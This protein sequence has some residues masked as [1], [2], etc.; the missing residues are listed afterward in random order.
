[1]SYTLIKRRRIELTEFELT[2]Y[3]HAPALHECARTTWERSRNSCTSS[4]KGAFPCMTDS[5]QRV[6]KCKKMRDGG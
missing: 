2:V 6:C 1:M 3:L 5:R 4:R